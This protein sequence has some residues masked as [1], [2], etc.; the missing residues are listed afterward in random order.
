MALVILAAVLLAFVTY[1][2]TSRA[3]SYFIDNKIMSESAIEKRNEKAVDEFA[4]FVSENNLSI[5]DTDKILNWTKMKKNVYISI[6]DG[7]SIILYFTSNGIEFYEPQEGASSIGISN[8]EATKKVHFADGDYEIHIYDDKYKNIYTF[9]VILSFAAS[10][11]ILVTTIILYTSRITKRIIA[12]SEIANKIAAG[13]LNL[14][15]KPDGNDEIYVLGTSIDNMRASLIERIEFEQQAWK[16][17]N[18]LLTSI[19]H[20][21]RTPLTVLMCTVEML[22]KG[23]YDGEDELRESLNIIKKQSSSLKTLADQLFLYFYLYGSR[24]LNL[25]VQKYDAHILLE[26]MITENTEQLKTLGYRLSFI[27]DVTGEICVDAS[28]LNRIF[29]NVFSNVEKH[30]DISR[31]VYVSCIRLGDILNVCVKNGISKSAEKKESTKIGLKT[32][33]KII[34]Q[35]SGRLYVKENK[36]SF[37][38][39]F[40]LPF[41]AASENLQNINNS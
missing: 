34:E 3:I 25:S 15:L 16:A 10:C 38:V 27:I 29:L 7:S 20:D 8:S 1:F 19:S 2:I 40:C 9:G 39:S 31:P 26:Q 24:A 36:N 41:A 4:K 11:L 30:A 37:T 14:P 13:E 21:I 28:Y 6:Y 35:M 23:Q 18:E 32:C 33:K 5:A 12:I 17:N 22:D